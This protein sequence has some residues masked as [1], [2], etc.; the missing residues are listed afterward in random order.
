LFDFTAGEAKSVGFFNYWRTGWK[1][2]KKG[3]KI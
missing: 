2:W 1:N 3:W